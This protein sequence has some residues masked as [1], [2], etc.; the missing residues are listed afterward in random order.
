M[1]STKFNTLLL[2]N[3][4]QLQ[5]F[6]NLLSDYVFNG[7]ETVETFVVQGDLIFTLDDDNTG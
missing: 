7:S 4:I 2:S 1:E 6:E 5:E 3:N